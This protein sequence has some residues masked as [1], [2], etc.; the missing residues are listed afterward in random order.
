[1]DIIA[2]S[3][4]NKTFRFSPYTQHQAAGGE[5]VTIDVYDNS[6][7]PSRQSNVIRLT[8]EFSGAA[9]VYKDETEAALYI[10]LSGL[11]ADPNIDFTIGDTTISISAYEYLAGYSEYL[12]TLPESET[13]LLYTSPSPRDR[14]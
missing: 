5:N 10:K 14:G 7:R 13:C 9:T 8:E 6:L 12:E 4:D 1:M 11:R 2:I 3:F